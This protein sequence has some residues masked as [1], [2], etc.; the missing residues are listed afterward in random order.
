[1]RINFVEIANYRKLLATRIGLSESN[2]VFVGANNSG[3]TSAI[4]ALR[5]FLIARERANFSFN[6]F[7]LSHWPTINRMGKLWEDSHSADLPLPIPDWDEVL[8]FLDVWLNVAE[9]EIHYVQKILPT[10]DWAGEDLGVRMRLEPK[11]AEDLQKDYLAARSAV[12]ALQKEKVCE[13]A[14]WPKDLED[15]LRK[16]FTKLFTIQSYILDPARRIEPVDGIATP[17]LLGSAEPIVGDP[18]EGLIRIDEIS[19]QRGFGQTKNSADED[20]FSPTTDSRKLSS[21]LQQYYRRH[22]DPTENPGATDLLALKAIE[23]AQQEFNAR[24]NVGFSRAIEEMSTL[25]YPG[26]T[27]PTLNISTRIRPVDGLSHSAAVQ[28]MMPIEDQGATLKL[29]LPE[30]SNGLG[31][32]NLISMV[33]RLMS[34]RDGWMRV[35]KARE[36]AAGNQIVPPLHLVLIE[37]PEAHLHT[38]V[39]QVFIRQAHK[40]LRNH[41]NLQKS[42]DFTTQLVVSTHSSHIA[43]EC[44]FDS[45]RYFRRLSGRVDKVPTSCVVNL[46]NVFGTDITT[47]R[48]VTRYLKVTHCDL[49]F[50]DAAVLIE[51]PAER[52]LIPFF[53]SS[54]PEF[55][56]LSES[57]I[58]WLEIGG[59]HAHRLRDLIEAIG[60]TTLV[61]TDIDS[62]DATGN[63]AIPQRTPGLK[64]KNHTLKTW[65]P[66]ESDL[67]ILL[68]MPETDKVKIYFQENFSVRV[69]YQ[70]PIIVTYKGESSEALANTL[71]DAIVT[72]NLSLFENLTGNGLI[73]KFRKATKESPNLN[74]LMVALREALGGG[75][76]AEFALDLLEIPDEKALQPPSYIREGL[77]WLAE[78]LQSKQIDLGLAQP[79][80]AHAENTMAESS[81]GQ[82]N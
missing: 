4:S 66:A 11:K 5:H 77:K 53:V 7:T 1:V 68:D 47:K 36:T 22:L 64:T 51:G 67:T 42:A 34:F 62:C 26:L 80:S 39:Q 76:K 31:Y 81:K 60:L 9:N 57:Y 20:D 69:A 73:A 19:A 2:T 75:D 43:H 14:L 61:I 45:L 3:K 33:F 27:D 8:P 46:K 79:K 6:D 35:G 25:G 30:D 70:K 82:P 23:D 10:L 12:V 41:N 28:F 24:L 38:Q 54:L 49:F 72:E 74:A 37:E 55:E 59:S 44:D 17:Q 50:A 13:V 29:H 32:Q 52:I 16:R 15:F 18:F 63:F 58:T 78:Q 21:Q 65:W 48:F 71:E 56:K 40:I